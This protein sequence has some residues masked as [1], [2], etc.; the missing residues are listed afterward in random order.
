M[1]WLLTLWLALPPMAGE[2]EVRMWFSRESYCT[3]AEEKLRENPMRRV[4]PDGAEGAAKVTRSQ[5]RELR[6]G[7]ANLI[8]EHMRDRYSGVQDQYDP[9]LAN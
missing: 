5:C 1:G 4:L 3:F 6:P 8:P 9:F 2:V 7:E